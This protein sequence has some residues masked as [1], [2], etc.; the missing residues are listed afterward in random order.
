MLNVSAPCYLRCA[1]LV[2]NRILIAHKTSRC[3]QFIG[4]NVISAESS[5][6]WAS[7]NRGRIINNLWFF[8]LSLTRFSFV[9]INEI[10]VFFPYRSSL[11][12]RLSSNDIVNASRK[13]SGPWMSSNVQIPLVNCCTVAWEKKRKIQAETL[14]LLAPISL[15]EIHS[16]ETSSVIP[17]HTFFSQSLACAQKRIQMM[18]KK[19]P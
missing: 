9:T 3:G 4:S 19:N 2:Y 11:I 16:A 14:N 12:F 1:C 5:S 17:F 10:Y 6:Y 8:S 18:K 13:C 7:A 15:R